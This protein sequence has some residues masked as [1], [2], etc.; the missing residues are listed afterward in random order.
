MLEISEI[1]QRNNNISFRKRDYHTMSLIGSAQHSTP[2]VN[3]R[4]LKIVLRVRFSNFKLVMFPGPTLVI[5]V[6]GRG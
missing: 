5:L 2:W 6:L 3:G 1:T 4:H